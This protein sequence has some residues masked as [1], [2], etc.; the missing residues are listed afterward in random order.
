MREFIFVTVGYIGTD[1]V[2]NNLLYLVR[3][4][5]ASHIFVLIHP[6]RVR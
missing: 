1:M 4:K 3:R 6:K 5:Q 2:G